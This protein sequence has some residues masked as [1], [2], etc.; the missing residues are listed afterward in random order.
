MRKLIALSLIVA[1]S[2]VVLAPIPASAGASTDAALALGAFAVLNQIVRGQTIFHPPYPAQ[3]PPQYPVYGPNPYP[4]GYP[5]SVM[6]MPTY[7]QYHSV[8]QCDG[9]LNAKY[10]ERPHPSGNGVE[11]APA[12]DQYGRTIYECRGRIMPGL[13]PTR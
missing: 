5:G 7:Q 4:Y 6:A 10:I 8:L 1:L 2:F 12:V 3:Y 11:Y 13:V 9:Q